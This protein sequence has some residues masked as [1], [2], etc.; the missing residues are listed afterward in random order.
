[1]NENKGLPK[2]IPSLDGQ[3]QIDTVGKLTKKRFIGDFTCR[4]PRVK[5][6]CLI[7][8]HE[9]FLNGQMAQFL[10]M[11]TLKMHRMVAYL[12][13]ALVGDMP[14]WW[15]DSDLGYE[16]QDLNVIEE[17]YNRVLEHENAWIKEIW[18][19]DPNSPLNQQE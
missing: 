10:K 15:K 19:D 5:E 13:F 8:K 9:A 4:I 12:R 18:G 6:Q 14:K 17:I 7:D 11:G 1:M 2:D 3:F 16:L